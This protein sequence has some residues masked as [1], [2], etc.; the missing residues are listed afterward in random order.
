VRLSRKR[1]RM[2][3]EKRKERRERKKEDEKGAG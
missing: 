3:E 2:G 1:G